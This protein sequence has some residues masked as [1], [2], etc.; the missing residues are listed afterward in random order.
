MVMKE[1]YISLWLSF[2]KP[3]VFGWLLDKQWHILIV[4]FEVYEC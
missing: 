2:K 3:M 4:E 1:I